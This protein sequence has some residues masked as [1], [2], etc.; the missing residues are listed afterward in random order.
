MKALGESADLRVLS[1]LLQHIASAPVTTRADLARATGLSRSTV[2]QRVDALLNTGLVSEGGAAPSSGGRPGLRLLLNPHAA[3]IVTADLGATWSRVAVSDLSGAERASIAFD[4]NIDQPPE[5]VLA[6]IDE[7][8]RQLLSQAGRGAIEVRAIVVGLP[9]PVEF[10]TGQPVR[11]PL[12]PSWDRY[13]VSSYFA[14]RYQAAVTL[15]DNDVN[16]MALGEYRTCYPSLD[17]LL[18]IKVGTGIGCGIIAGRRLYR[19]AEGAA[20]DIGHIRLPGSDVPC[21]CG[22]TG[23]L[24]AAAG[25]HALAQQLAAKGLPAITARDVAQLAAEGDTQARHHVRQAAQHIGDVLAAIVSFTN[26]AAV[27]IGGSLAQLDE[28]LLAGIRSGI[29]N[30]ALPLATRSLQIETSILKERAGTAGA[31]AL[32]Q[33]YLLSHQG[34]PTLLQST[35]GHRRPGPQPAPD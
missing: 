6:R 11:P 33:E 27:I 2:S 9:S 15:A 23:C 7:H 17:H 19:G 24:E 30:R 4:L 20:G 31:I 13:Q 18:F 16:L 8:A 25:G 32:A 5:R 29:Y 34:I 22:N 26:P 35:I 3:V 21:R 10:A 14:D 12:M 28:T 1:D